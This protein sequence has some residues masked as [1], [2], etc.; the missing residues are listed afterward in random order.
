[1]EAELEARVKRLEDRQ[2]IQENRQ[3]AH[4]EKLHQLDNLLQL[5]HAAIANIRFVLGPNE[6]EGEH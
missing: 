5:V 4:G 6:D 3:R 1:M 2:Q